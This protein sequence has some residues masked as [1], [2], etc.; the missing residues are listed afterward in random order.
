MK[1]REFLALSGCGAFGLA[2]LSS[3]GARPAWA[4]QVTPLWFSTLFHGGDAKA[5]EM[6]VKKL[7]EEQKT[8]RIDL[9]QGGWTEYYAQLYNAVVAGVAPNIGICHDFRF[10]STEPA[11]YPLADTPAGNLLEVIKLGEAD[12]VAPA[13]KLPQVKG[14]QYGIPLDQSMI[15]FYYNK[16]IFK[17]AGL[18]PETPPKTR[19][20]F[21][22]ACEAI[23]K[24]GKLAFHPAFS[25]AP[26]W[27]RRAFFLLHWGGGGELIENNKA[28]FNTPHGLE[29]L[30]YLVDMVGKRGWNKPGTDANKQFLAG[31]L[32]M[33]FNGTWFYLTVAESKIDY[34]SGVMPTFYQKPKTW[35]SAHNLVL[36]KQPSGKANE[37]RLKVAAS[38]IK[39]ISDNSFLWGQYGG[40][41]PVRKAAQ[42]DERLRSSDTWKKTLQHF[43]AMSQSGVFQMEPQH[44]KIVEFDDAI[45]P[46]LQEAYN[47]TVSPKD[48]LDKAE[49]AANDV[50]KG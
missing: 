19:D 38:A 10:I 42:E 36:P 45:E 11:L 27:I 9:T 35:G 32:G 23:K 22:K 15:G 21:E 46:I 20:E 40:H 6:I 24:T 25:S 43:A 30:T 4:Q 14:V 48:A 31:E 44:P 49:K 41:V 13:W 1:R 28:A 18:D 3:L 50:L 47:G 39:A 16:A 7:N 33:C 2:A 5:M 8:F 37:E 34:G 29:A 17:E 12:F 26:R